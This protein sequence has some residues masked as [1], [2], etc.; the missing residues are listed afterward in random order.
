MSKAA[1]GSIGMAT[2]GRRSVVTCSRR[3]AWALPSSVR[4]AGSTSPSCNA[5]PTCPKRSARRATPLP[6]RPRQPAA[7]P[8]SI[9]PVAPPATTVPR[10]TRAC[11]PSPYLHHGSVRTMKELLTPP[12]ARAKSFHRGSRQYDAV[13]MGY[14]DDGPYTL[15][16]G[17]PGN[18]SAGH[19]YGTDLTD[20]QKRDLIE[21]LK[22]R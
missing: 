13:Q 18:S 8:C 17:S 15:D 1:A 5:R 10:T 2:P 7:A 20:A 6:L 3:S 16:T 4:S 22:T 14:T 9:R 21:Y 11:A 12:P 19:D